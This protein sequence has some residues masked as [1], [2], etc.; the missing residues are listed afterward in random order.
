[1]TDIID[2]LNNLIDAEDAYNNHLQKKQRLNHIDETI[3]VCN[4]DINDDKINN[5]QCNDS[6]DD[7]LVLSDDDLES[8]DSDSDCDFTYDD[9]EDE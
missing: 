2:I 8:I 5:S 4:N 7:D 9:K 6:S 1:M 3:S